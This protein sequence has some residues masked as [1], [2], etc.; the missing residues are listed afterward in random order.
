M[1][2]K[3]IGKHVAAYTGKALSFSLFLS[4]KYYL[5]QKETNIDVMDISVD[6]RFCIHDLI[7]E[8]D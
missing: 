4:I 6:T 1:A 2:K 5:A 8:D 7:K 3:T